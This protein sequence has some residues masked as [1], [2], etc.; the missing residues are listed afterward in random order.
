MPLYNPVQLYSRA[1]GF[2]FKEYGE[3][4]ATTE[5]SKL[6]GVARTIR[7]VSRKTNVD[8]GTLNRLS[9]EGLF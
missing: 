2:K 6:L 1:S 4:H 9:H 3:C 5:G 7:V 8:V